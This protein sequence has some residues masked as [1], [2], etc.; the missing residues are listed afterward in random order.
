MFLEGAIHALQ[1]SVQEWV[2]AKLRE[3]EG[4]QHSKPKML[5]GSRNLRDFSHIGGQQFLRPMK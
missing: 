1:E 2:L 3:G 5:G 4:D